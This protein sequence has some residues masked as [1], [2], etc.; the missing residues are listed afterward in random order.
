MALTRLTLAHTTHVHAHT[1][2]H[3]HTH[4]TPQVLGADQFDMTVPVQCREKDRF[5][6]WFYWAINIGAAIA[7]GWLANLSLNGQGTVL[8]TTILL[9]FIIKRWG[10]FP[11]CVLTT[12]V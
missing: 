3:T 5:F 10:A 4:P 7:F 8:L 2:T 9:D 12:Q 6:N 11:P 1:H